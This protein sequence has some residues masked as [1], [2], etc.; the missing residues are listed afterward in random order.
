ML[1]HYCLLL[2]CI[3]GNYRYTMA[4]ENV[5]KTIQFFGAKGDGKTNDTEAFIKATKFFNDRGGN[6]TLNIPKG[7]YIVGR[8]TFSN[9]DANKYA[10]TGVDILDFKN[11]N[12][13]IIKGEKG[14]IIKYDDSLKLGSF[15]PLTGKVFN[16]NDLVRPL[17]KY[18][19]VIGNCIILTN[20]KNV[21]VTKLFLDGNNKSIQFGGRYGDLGIQLMHVGI[22]TKDCH[23]ILIDNI[24][25]SHFGLDGIMIS[26][27]LSPTPDDIRLSN[28]ICEYNSRQGLSWVGGNS[29]VVK[30]CQFNHTGKIGYY[31]APGAGVDIE[32]E[33]GSIS[34]GFFT[35]CQFI[36]N[37]GCG[38]VSDNGSAISNC[39]FSNCTFWGTTN[40]SVWVSSPSFTFNGCKI[41]GSIVHGYNAVNDKDA[42]RYINC[43]FEDK[44]YNN[45]PPYGKFIIECDGPR[46]MLFDSCTF[47]TNTTQVAWLNTGGVSSEAEKAT[48]RNCHFII[49]KTV[50]GKAVFWFHNIHFK[51]NTVEFKDPAAK[52][53]GFWAHQCCLSKEDWDATKIIYSE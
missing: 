13:L 35:D 8:Q 23:S 10:Y 9:G 3:T 40:W 27:K 26:N 45:K 29:L 12:N 39:N 22:Y 30:N 37:S 51:N 47:T 49:N 2:L 24:N 28:V 4:Q 50:N 7:T 15:D 46:K 32:S 48:I 18:A 41:Y 20:C 36:D 33:V 14:T 5:S 1:K 38:M 16:D 11:I 42:T 17:I 25:T 53:K 34:N 31:S 44:P 6:G 21:T 19:G 43:F 52:E